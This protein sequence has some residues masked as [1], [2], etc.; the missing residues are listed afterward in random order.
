[1]HALNNVHRDIKC[2]N[3]LVMSDG[4]IKVSD[5]GSSCRLSE[6]NSEQLDTQGTYNWMAP[7]MITHDKQH[8]YDN[9]VDIWSFGCSLIEM[10]SSGMPWSEIS[11]YGPQLMFHIATFNETV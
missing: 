7:E 1:M 8:P 10:C 9:K 4:I 3:L 5:F 11:K 6:T 2:A